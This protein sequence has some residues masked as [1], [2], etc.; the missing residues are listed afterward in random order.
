MPNDRHAVL[1]GYRFRL[2]PDAISYPYTINYSTIDTIGGQVIQVLGATLGNLVIRGSFGQDHKGKKESWE[3]ALDFHRHI[4]N[5][6]D[7]QTDLTPG[8]GHRPVEFSYF[9]GVH[10]WDF[11]VL[12]MGIS[13]LD[14][15]GSLN[16]SNGKFSYQYQLNLFIVQDR[17]LELNKLETDRFIERAASGMGWKA[18]GFNGSMTLDGAIQYIRSHSPSGTFEGYIGSLLGITDTAAGGGSGIVATGGG[19][20]PDQNR[21]LAKQMCAQRGQGWDTGEQWDSLVKLWNQESGWSQTADTRKTHSGGDTMGSSV[22]AYG[23]AQAR[24]A[25]KYPKAGQPADLGGQSDPRVQMEW[26]LN[27]IGERYGTPVDAWAYEVA[28]GSY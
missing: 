2:D 13:D 20:T 23:I 14:Q 12:V 28:N 26:G 4:R 1:D 19:G 15:K 24:P 17:S 27:Y 18:S 6:M 11:Q 7:K 25:T 3:L 22:F 16:H 5:L 10:N 8:R 9:D 21:A